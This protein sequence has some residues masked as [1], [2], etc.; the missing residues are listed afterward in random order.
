MEK[1]KPE[2]HI[3]IGIGTRVR[4]VINYCEILLKEKHLKEI[5]L[6]A[7]GGAI[8]SLIIVI[9]N[10]KILHPG[11]HQ[12]YLIS[13]INSQTVDKLG[14]IVQQKLFPKMQVALSFNEPLEKNE[15]YQ[16]PLSNQEREI[17]FR[18]LN[19]K[20]QRLSQTQIEVFRGR[21][22]GDR[23]EIEDVGFKPFRAFR[24]PRKRGF[25]DRGNRG[26]RRFGEGEFSNRSQRGFYRGSRRRGGYSYL[27]QRGGY[28][29]MRSEKY[30]Y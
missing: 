17:L 29:G 10:L 12:N 2:N 27:G 26:Y 30:D 6:N 5:N 11:L 25:I 22:R 16:P 20:N 15:G 9:E 3:K 1:E 18:K 8:E 23:G 7:I 14:K 21:Y 24:G 19:S 4:S 28:R 13:T